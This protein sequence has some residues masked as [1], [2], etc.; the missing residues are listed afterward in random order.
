MLRQFCRV[1][2]Q[3]VPD[4]TTLLRWATRIQPTS[5]QRL[6]DHVVDLARHRQVTRGRKLRLDSTVVSTT[7]HYPV[8]STLLADGVRVLARMIRRAKPLLKGTVAH[9]RTLFR[10]R[11]RSVRR[12]THHLIAATRRRGEQAAQDVQQHSRHLLTLTQQVVHQAH[13]V[14]QH[15]QTHV[16]QETD[17]LAQRLT[18]TLQTFVPRGEQVI[19][20]TTRRV[21]QGEPVPASEKR[22]SLCAPHTAIIRKGKVGKPVE[23]GRVLWLGEVEGGIMTQAQVLAGHPDDAAQLVPSLDQHLQ[24]FGRPPNL[25][26]GDGKRATATNEQIA[27]QP[28]VKHVVLP[29]PGRKAPARVAHERQRWLRKGRD[30]RAGIEGRISGLKRRHGLDRCRYHGSDGMERWVGWGVLAHNLRMIAQHQAV[31]AIRYE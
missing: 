21:V 25:L 16:Q 19:Q 31:K 23:F 7:V 4:D 13:Q 11:T 1:Y 24:Q 15:L 18:P 29:R 3:R 12:V 5:L 6:L 28:G 9:A 26:A 17:R 30:W 27:L 20:Q 14:Q 2:A 8:D 10:D 22:V